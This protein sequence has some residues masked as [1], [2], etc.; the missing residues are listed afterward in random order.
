MHYLPSSVLPG[1][2]QGTGFLT[3]AEW[4]GPDFWAGEV[5]KTKKFVK[6]LAVLP[7]DKCQHC[8]LIE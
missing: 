4:G 2:V 8:K 3:E 5:Y 7:I 1:D 6:H